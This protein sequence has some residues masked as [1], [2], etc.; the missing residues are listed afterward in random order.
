MKY[1]S[2]CGKEINDE[3]VI[4]TSCGCEIKPLNRHNASNLLEINII[5]FMIFGTIAKFF[6]GL[7]LITINSVRIYY[8]VSFSRIAG[9]I[10]GLFLGLV[11][12]TWC[13]PMTAIIISKIKHSEKIGT[14]LKVCTLLFV[15]LISGILLLCRN[16]E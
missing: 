5:F 8:S 2:H 7:I 3:A 14:G 10:Y 6:L 15:S 11:P 1:C 16:D 4:C 9:I 13:I 12:L